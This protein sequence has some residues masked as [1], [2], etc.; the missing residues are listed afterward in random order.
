MYVNLEGK[1]IELTSMTK[2]FLVNAIERYNALCT[3]RN[4]HF[5]EVRK[6]KETREALKV[7]LAFRLKR[8]FRAI[9]D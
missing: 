6:L 9:T 4:L 8:K 3:A 5:E 1:E 2:S 7:E